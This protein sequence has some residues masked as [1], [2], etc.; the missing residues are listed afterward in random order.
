MI[1]K[2]HDSTLQPLIPKK[3]ENTPSPPFLN[4]CDLVYKPNRFTDRSHK[5][6]PSGT[7][8][9]ARLPCLLR[10]TPPYSAPLSMRI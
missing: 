2:M 3:A 7:F 9:Q 6:H 4:Y 1:L 10:H 8:Y 5:L